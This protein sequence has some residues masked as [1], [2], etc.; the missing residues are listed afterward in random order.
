[1]RPRLLL[2]VVLAAVA[3]TPSGAAAATVNGRVVDRPV[4]RGSEVRLPV[5][6][7]ARTGARLATLVLPRRALT[8]P[9][10]LR[11]VR[12]SGAGSRGAR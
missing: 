7:R 12:R 3:A 4:V 11:P 2:L 9:A 10:S 8:R 1:M 5:L 6:V